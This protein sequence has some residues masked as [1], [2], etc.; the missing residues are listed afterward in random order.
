MLIPAR[1][2]RVCD[3]NI[4]GHDCDVSLGKVHRSEH[5]HAI[6]HGDLV[7]GEFSWK[8]Q[9]DRG[10]AADQG[11]RPTKQPNPQQFYAVHSGNF[12]A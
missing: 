5:V 9:A 3:S 2:S 8:T 6:R 1:L 10:L 4:M 7:L 12:T 11:V